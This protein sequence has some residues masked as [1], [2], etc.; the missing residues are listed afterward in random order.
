MYKA[1]IGITMGDPASIGPEIALKAL[2]DTR[3]QAICKPILVGDAAVFQQ[4]ASLLHIP[5][6]IHAVE[7]VS[8]A[9]FIAGEADVLDLK[10]TECVC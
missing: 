10:N 1:I 7:Q 8:E 4:I 5:I 2:L 3:V 9:Q 6:R